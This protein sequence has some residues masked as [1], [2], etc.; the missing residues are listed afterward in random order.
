MYVIVCEFVMCGEWSSSLSLCLTYR[1]VCVMADSG[2][3]EVFYEGVWTPI[4]R[5]SFHVN[6]NGAAS[7][8]SSLGFTGGTVSATATTLDRDALAVGA[9]D[10]GEFPFQCSLGNNSY[11]VGAAGCAAGDSSATLI[12]CTG[13]GGVAQECTGDPAGRARA[14][15]KLAECSM[16]RLCVAGCGPSHEHA[17]AAD[18]CVCVWLR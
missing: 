1:L 16:N 2:V 15:I 7:L 12:T 17:P 3:A 4:C 9:C 18:A 14:I 13:S 5:S 8:C 10:T 11:T 6:S